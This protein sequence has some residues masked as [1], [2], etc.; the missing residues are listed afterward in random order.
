MGYVVRLAIINKSPFVLKR[1][2][3]TEYQMCEWWTFPAS[4]QPGTIAHVTVEFET[5]AGKTIADDSGEVIYEVNYPSAKKDVLRIHAWAQEPEKSLGIFSPY[6]RWGPKHLQIYGHKDNSVDWREPGDFHYLAVTPSNGVLPCEDGG[7]VEIIVDI[8][9][10]PSKEM[11]MPSSSTKEPINNPLYGMTIGTVIDGLTGKATASVVDGEITI[12][13]PQQS[14]KTMMTGHSD[15]VYSDNMNQG[16]LSVVGSYGVSGISELSGALSVYFGKSTA[17]STKTVDVTYNAI[18]WGGIE[19]IDF[20][21][22]S[23]SEFIAGLKSNAQ[24]SVLAVFE[25][26]TALKKELGG[27]TLTEAY[28]SPKKPPKLD[29]LLKDWTSLS[30]RFISNNGDGIV[31]GI[32]WGGWGSVHM[33]LTSSGAQQ[34]LNYGG[35]GEFSYAGVDKSMA[36][37]AIYDGSQSESS[38]GVIVTCSSDYSGLCMKEIVNNWFKT[39]SEKS[40]SDLANI[41]VFEKAPGI[42]SGVNKPNIPEFVKPKPDNTLTSKI[43]QISNLEGLKFYAQVAAYEKEKKENPKITLDDFIKKLDKPADLSKLEG[44]AKEIKTNSVG[45]LP[46]KLHKDSL[47]SVGSAKAEQ[48]KSRKEISDYVPLG[49]WI[50]NWADLFPWLATGYDNNISNDDNARVQVKAHTM[51]QDF[52]TLSRLYYRVSQA[53]FYLETETSLFLDYDTDAHQIADAFAHAGAILI[54]K[55]GSIPYKDTQAILAA[56]DEAYKGLNTAGRTIYKKW[57]ETKF[58][59][60]CELGVGITDI[61][62]KSISAIEHIDSSIKISWSKCCYSADQQNHS[63]FASFVKGCPVITPLG[64]IVLLITSDCSAGFLIS[65]PERVPGYILNPTPYVDVDGEV[66]L[67]GP[68]SPDSGKKVLTNL[69]GKGLTLTPIPFS[70]AKG[71]TWKGSLMS[72]GIGACTGLKE[73]LENLQKRLSNRQS[74]TLSS[75]HWE[76]ISWEEGNCYSMKNLRTSYIGLVEEVGDI[77]GKSE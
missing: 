21:N 59:R 73:Q 53:V 71:I 22:L 52:M 49:V 66:T 8:K 69:E 41:S 24:K 31:V 75:E 27:L 10:N 14:G 57:D 38:S 9:T 18:A 37:K 44:L 33:S 36:V 51:I 46:V 29:G 70:A 48:P 32:L 40:F 30:E 67:A 76:N 68:Y 45:V 74:W 43:G 47:V 34:K 62:G 11:P 7:S 58:L 55:I 1:Q 35:E 77:F 50:T 16:S 13:V 5:A 61:D 60:N 65:V 42:T 39:V 12:M 56:T 72:T 20:N 17:K 4:I 28:K 3:S 6:E 19:C 26:Y 54:E 25:A 63:A 15:Y 23:V 2:R 64:E